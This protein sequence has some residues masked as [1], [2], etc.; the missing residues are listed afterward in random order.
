[1]LNLCWLFLISGIRILSLGSLGSGSSCP[2]ERDPKRG[3]LQSGGEAH[4]P[5]VPWVSLFVLRDRFNMWQAALLMNI[6]IKSTRA[7]AAEVSFSISSRFGADRGFAPPKR[8]LGSVPRVPKLP[9]FPLL[10]GGCPASPLVSVGEINHYGER[11][12]GAL[13]LVCRP[14]GTDAPQRAPGLVRVC[15]CVYPALLPG[16]DTQA[17]K[18]LSYKTFYFSFH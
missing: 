10:V 9:K 12:H 7:L 14:A 4:Q 18:Q 15:T 3:T 1:M 5:L 11:A 13:G 8:G 2:W 17:L 16:S 6:S